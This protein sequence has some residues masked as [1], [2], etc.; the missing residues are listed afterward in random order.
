MVWI[1]RK[2]IIAIAS[3]I[4]AVII[5]VVAIHIITK[6]KEQERVG[7]MNYE[8][9]MSI[10]QW[11]KFVSTDLFEKALGDYD[12][13][14]GEW[15]PLTDIMYAFDAEVYD[16]ERMYTLCLQGIQSIAPDLVISDINEDL[17]GMTDEMEEPANPYEPPTDGVRSV[18]FKCNGHEYSITMASY[19]DWFNA[20]FIPFMNQVL[21]KENKTKRLWIL[22]DGL[23]QMAAIV[24]DT[25]EN[26]R[27]FVGYTEKSK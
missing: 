27:S 25:A 24:Y 14:T 8:I 21:E 6:R 11:R 7:V 3:I 17:T 26:A 16:V 12:W 5:I 19:G 13:D 4:L 18:S 9:T 20:E 15:K 22:S 10:D 2:R 23:D 1:S